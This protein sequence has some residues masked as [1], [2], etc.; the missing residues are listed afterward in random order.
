MSARILS[1]THRRESQRA[2]AWLLFLAMW[3]LF[4]V[5]AL[6][7]CDPTVPEVPDEQPPPAPAPNTPEG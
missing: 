6:V 5:L 1:P 7:G 2:R 3:A 4:F